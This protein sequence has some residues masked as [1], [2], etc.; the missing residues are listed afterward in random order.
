MTDF[1]TNV[2]N[3]LKDVC[4]TDVANFRFRSA[5]FIFECHKTIH[6]SPCFQTIF[7]SIIALAGIVR[8]LLL[9][10]DWVLVVT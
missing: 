5:C 9:S 1:F 10:L 4:R 7:L 3:V 8:M 6:A 2:D